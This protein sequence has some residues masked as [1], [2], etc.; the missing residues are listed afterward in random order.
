MSSVSFPRS[1]GFGCNELDENEVLQDY[2]PLTLT[3]SCV[4][5]PFFSESFITFFRAVVRVIVVSGVW[6]TSSVPELGGVSA[7]IHARPRTPFTHHTSICGN[8]HSH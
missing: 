5:F 1:A 2:N 4:T 6:F 8:K 3:T 7:A